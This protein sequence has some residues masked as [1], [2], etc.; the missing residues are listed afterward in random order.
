MQL[1]QL[2]AFEKYGLKYLQGPLNREVTDV[3]PPERAHKTSLVFVSRQEMVK[4][5]LERGAE[6]F[7]KLPAVQFNFPEN[8]T[9]FEVPAVSLG[10][11]LVLPFFDK[12]AARF[13]SSNTAHVHP[14]ARIGDNVVLGPFAVIGAN[15]I[16]GS[17]CKIGAHAVV[18]NH[19]LIGAKTILH[20]HVYIG[21]QTE[22]GTECEIHSHTSIGSDGYGY[23]TNPADGTHHKVPQI[24]RV[25][26]EDRVEIGANCAIDRATLTETR[27]KSGTKLDNLIH[28]AHNCEIGEN[29]L[30]TAG[31]AMAGSSKIGKQFIT[32][33]QSGVSDHTTITDNVTL[34]GRTAVLSDITE[35]GH[36]GGMPVVKAQQYLRI[37]RAL[38]DLPDIWKWWR[39]NNKS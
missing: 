20:P 31:F 35:P 23:V 27:I 1:T 4:Q 9:V 32:G 17:G 36:Y 25:I 10:L 3:L 6:N 18:E 8:A 13:E 38:L 34:A 5:A 11:A 15:T 28:I 26:I 19:C 24:G 39:K 16:I 21:S 14:T 2:Q 37:S 12:K 33:G 22:I 29:G 7:V 30:I